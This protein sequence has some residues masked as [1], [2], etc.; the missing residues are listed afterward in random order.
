[1]ERTVDFLTQDDYTDLNC[2]LMLLEVEEQ[3][4]GKD[5]RKRI[6]EI[7]TLLEIE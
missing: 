4:E 7:K 2:E 3:T 5:N 1:M 6:D